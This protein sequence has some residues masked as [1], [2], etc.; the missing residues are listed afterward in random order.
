M[1]R[2]K[3]WIGL[4]YLAAL[5]V[6]LTDG[7]VD[8]SQLLGPLE[9]FGGLMRNFIIFQRVVQGEQAAGFFCG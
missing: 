8:G 6:D 7:I 1:A 2:W 4:V 5:R 9:A 3:Y